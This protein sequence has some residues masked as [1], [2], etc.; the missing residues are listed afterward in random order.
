M[1]SDA[2]KQNISSMI[3]IIEDYKQ[4]IV[5]LE[6]VEKLVSKENVTKK[7]KHFE[8]SMLATSKVDLVYICLFHAKFIHKHQI[9]YQNIE[10]I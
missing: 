8:V 4:K 5:L 10:Q 6:I 1:I 3:I 7:V 9:Q 2:H